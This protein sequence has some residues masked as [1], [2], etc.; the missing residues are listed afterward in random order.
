MLEP[1]EVGLEK[2]ER[3][4]ERRSPGVPGRGDEEAVERL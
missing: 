1:T 3:N 4:E 2:K